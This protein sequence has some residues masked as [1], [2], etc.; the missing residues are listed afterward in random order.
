MEPVD[1]RE[2]DAEDMDYTINDHSMSEGMATDES[3]R[4]ETENKVVKRHF[5]QL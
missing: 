5:Q 4:Y 1:I 2:I 3:M